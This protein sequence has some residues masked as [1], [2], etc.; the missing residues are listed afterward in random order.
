LV[1]VVFVV[2]ERAPAF[3]VVAKAQFRGNGWAFIMAQIV[4]EAA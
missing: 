2:I 4:M 1:V 3:A